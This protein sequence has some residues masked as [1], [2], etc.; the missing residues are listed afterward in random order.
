MSG[1]FRTVAVYSTPKLHVFDYF[2]RQ[3]FTDNT[4][5]SAT[6]NTAL[7]LHNYEPE[8]IH[9]SA[10]IEMLIIDEDRSQQAMKEEDIRRKSVL[11]LKKKVEIEKDQTRLVVNMVGELVTP[12]LWS[13]ETPNLYRLF[14]VLTDEQSGETIE[15]LAGRIGIRRIEIDRRKGKGQVLLNG[16]PIKFKGVNRHEFDQRG[17]IGVVSKASML[18]DIFLLKQNNFNAVRTSHYPNHPLWYHLCDEYGIYLIDETNLETHKLFD[19]FSN[20]PSW[21]KC[22]LYRA[23]NLVHR[24]LLYHHFRPPPPLHP[25]IF[26]P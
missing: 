14:I 21:K 6:I 18:Q 16:V 26:S 2:V 10:E 23:K 1:I 19:H 13:A 5:T 9:T 22:F 8:V 25:T 15:V 4:P 17:G 24:Y 7:T 11:T 20:L 3:S 12:N